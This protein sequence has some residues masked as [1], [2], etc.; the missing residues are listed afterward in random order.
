MI[1]VKKVKNKLENKFCI[2]KMREMLTG[3]LVKKLNEE[4]LC[5]EELMHSTINTLKIEK[6]I[7]ST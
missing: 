6:I 7:F 4:I 2:E 1:Q 3:V 5:W